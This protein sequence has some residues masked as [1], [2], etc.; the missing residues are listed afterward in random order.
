MN[1]I[2]C[3]KR[4]IH[5]LHLPI[6]ASI[7]KQKQNMQNLIF[8][9]NHIQIIRKYKKKYTCLLITIKTSS[10]VHKFNTKKYDSTDYCQLKKHFALFTSIL[11]NVLVM[12]PS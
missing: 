12:K 11:G 7:V 1:Y 3:F 2:T 6:Q 9:Y 5:D 10:S 8:F 4:Q